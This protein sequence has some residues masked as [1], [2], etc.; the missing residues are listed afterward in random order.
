MENPLGLG[1]TGWSALQFKRGVN[2]VELREFLLDQGIDRIGR[3]T[4][5]RPALQ[6]PLNFIGDL[7]SQLRCHL[8]MPHREELPDKEIFSKK[9]DGEF[10]VGWREGHDLGLGEC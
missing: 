3:E 2:E 9:G 6:V 8:P 4:R 1:R 10:L 5:N 7:V